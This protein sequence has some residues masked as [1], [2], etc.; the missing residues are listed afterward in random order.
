M[1]ICWFTVWGTKY[2]LPFSIS[3]DIQERYFSDESPSANLMDSWLRGCPSVPKSEGGA[4]QY[5]TM[6]HG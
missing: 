5:G 1:A 3:D 6:Y 2:F 4:V